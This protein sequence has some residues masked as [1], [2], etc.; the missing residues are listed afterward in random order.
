M[1]PQSFMQAEKVRGMSDAPGL[2]KPSPLEPAAKAS[3]VEAA[4][5]DSEAK[6]RT[7]EFFDGASACSKVDG[8]IDPE[9]H[10]KYYSPGAVDTDSNNEAAETEY[11]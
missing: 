9:G 11:Q 5:G 6:C 2:G 4:Y 7:C 3:Q 8:E 10:S 1:N